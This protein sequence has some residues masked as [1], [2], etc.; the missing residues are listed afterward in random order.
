[1]SENF[2][3]AA[4]VCVIGGGAAGMMAAI[5][6]AEAG[7]E[8]TLIERNDKC[9]KKLRIT[10]KGRCN[11]TNACDTREFLNHVPTN[12]R[13]LY[14]ALNR[15]STE[16][17]VEFFENAGVPLKV[18]RGRRVFPVSDKA[19]DIVF[20]LTRRLRESGVRILHARAEALEVLDGA[21]VGCRAS[22]ELIEADAV[23]VATGGRS[24]PGTGSDGDGY[25]L[26]R[27]VGHSVSPLVPSL[28][29]LVSKSKICP[30]LQG[31]SLKNV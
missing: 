15:L 8:V 22:G 13:F 23:I 16:D 31:L 6:A 5:S 19:E 10:G 28:V 3:R 30:S 27:S 7:A 4:R 12:P 1:M 29:P 26:A 20:A 24:Y 21:A 11:V 18:E 25:T 17:T 14:S 2:E 9:G